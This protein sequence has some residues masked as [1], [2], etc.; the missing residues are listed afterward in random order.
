MNLSSEVPGREALLASALLHKAPPRSTSEWWRGAMLYEVY[1]RSFYDTT[2][3]GT[4]D[5]PG[6]IEKLDYIRDL[7]VDG[8]W[9]TP[10][11]PS[12]QKDFGY[13]ITDFCAVDER[14]GTM[15]DF[16]RLLD[17]CHK[18]DLKLLL[19]FVPVH[20]SD[21]HPWFVESRQSRDNPRADWYIW[22]DGAPDGGPPN[23]WLSS[24]G[25]SAW[26]WDPRRAQYYY[27]PFL[28]GQP[29]FNLQKP[30]VMEA[31]VAHMRFWLDMGVDGFRLDAVQ[32]LCC[33]LSLRS[34]PPAVSEEEN[35]MVGGGPHNP[36][37]RQLHL[38]DRDVPEAIP[39]IEQ[40]RKVADSYRPERVLIGELADMDS[41]RF[42]VKY[43][44]AN[45]RFHAIYD[46]DLINGAHSVEKWVDVL[47][48]RMRYMASGWTK[49]VFTNHDSTR[50]VSNLLPQAVEAGRAADA[51]KA[52]IFLQS[53]L[54]GGGILYQGDELGLPQ[55]QLSYDHI[56][57][58]W[59]KAF[60]PEFQGRDG[61]RT[62]LPWKQDAPHGGFTSGDH[63]WLP[64]P[65]EHRPLAIDIQ[66]EDEHS[67][68]NFTRWMLQWRKDQPLT[69][70]GRE[71]IHDDVAAPLICFDRCS[72][73]DR[74]SFIANLGLDPL[75]LPVDGEPLFE[76]IGSNGVTWKDGAIHLEGLAFA[77]YRIEGGMNG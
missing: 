11:Y 6:V 13:D 8:F 71:T 49:N 26:S 20:S 74:V 29:S 53:T 19:D 24:F 48:R 59:A 31:V 65:D 21:E 56:Y 28:Q 68:L 43:T 22:A 34:N 52:L 37:K 58:P 39:V 62:P 10:F 73:T 5:I 44:M 15:D 32:C 38:F 18:R 17:E 9:L 40:F 51:A 76:D 30:E 63:P 67:V 55:P 1:I 45:E 61:V 75:S 57:D 35:G 66:Q 16:R 2:G 33:D 64:M 70:T 7:G 72:D 23:N 25:G 50:V 14:Y 3:S 69:R 12:P 46:F 4:G 27:H 60:W 54:L 47:R 41:S 77:A 36:F 42:S